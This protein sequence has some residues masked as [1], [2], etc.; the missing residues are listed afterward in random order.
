MTVSV[1]RFNDPNYSRPRYRLR[2]SERQTWLKNGYTCESHKLKRTAEFRADEL[3]MG[4]DAAAAKRDGRYT[5]GRE[6]YCVGDGMIGE[7]WVVYFLGV[8]VDHAATL[9]DSYKIAGAH[10][11]ARIR[12]AAE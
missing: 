4:H 1:E 5:Y 6:K 7:R 10:I 3:N 12:R 9:V 11:V 2:Y 8:R